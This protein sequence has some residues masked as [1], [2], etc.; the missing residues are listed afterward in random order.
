[1]GTLALGTMQRSFSS[2]LFQGFEPLN[3]TSV[4][5]TA[6]AEN[7]LAVL[8]GDVPVQGNA[9]GTA[10]NYLELSW[11]CFPQFWDKTHGVVPVCFSQPWLGAPQQ[12]LASLGLVWPCWLAGSSADTQ[13]GWLLSFLFPWEK[14][15]GSAFII[16]F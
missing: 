2:C 13:T 16:S 10:N 3:Q 12:P 11:C 8:R 14:S 6:K 9:A 4:A 1:M 5:P 15:Q 7:Q